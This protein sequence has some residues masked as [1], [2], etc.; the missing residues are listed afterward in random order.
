MKYPYEAEREIRTYT[1]LYM[2]SKDA[3]DAAT[4]SKDGQ[5]FKIIS[6]LVFA[7]F[8]LEAY[9][10]HIGEQR[11]EYWEEI[12]SIKTTSKLKII[13]TNLGLSYDNSKRPIQTIIELLR[14]RNIMAHGRTE[15]IQEQGYIKKEKLDPDE[16]F[17]IGKWE[18]F[19]NLKEAKRAIEDAKAIMESMCEASGSK[20]EL[21]FDYGYSQS[22]TGRPKP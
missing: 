4:K 22:V 21:L 10:N 18:K 7:A 15:R 17:I 19:V 5:F 12:E 9:I 11:I 16:N 14:F 8:S 2:V 6:S 3:L 13:Y 20:K 1:Y